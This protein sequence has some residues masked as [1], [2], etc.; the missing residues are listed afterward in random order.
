MRFA[1]DR[2]LDWEKERRKLLRLLRSEEENGGVR[3]IRRVAYLAVLYIQL[4]NGCRI[5]E[6]A[7]AAIRFAQTGKREVEVRVRKRRD[8]ALR[9]VI[10]PRE[11]AR[12]RPQIR[13]VVAEAGEDPHRLAER[14]RT[15]ASRRLGNTHAY[16]YAFIGYMAKRGV[17]AQLIAKITGHRKL[18]Y[19]L[20][21]TQ[22]VKAEELLEEVV[23][24]A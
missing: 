10:I 16:R 22:K 13:T 14:V 15:W 18:D 11:I 21:Y 2:G 12:Y 24:G 8:N 3:A 17:A 7:E 9:K 23:D 20:H 19:V 1:W 4:S 6:A 5:S